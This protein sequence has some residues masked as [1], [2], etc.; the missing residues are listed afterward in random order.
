MTNN[1]QVALDN[2]V[3]LRQ[4][5]QPPNNRHNV[6]MNFDTVRF[7]IV[8][9]D[10]EFLMFEPEKPKEDFSFEKLHEELGRPI[11]LAIKERKALKESAEKPLILF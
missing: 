10:N 5:P 4:A 9:D 6:P 8:R 11:I 1:Q 7:D 2:S 3:V